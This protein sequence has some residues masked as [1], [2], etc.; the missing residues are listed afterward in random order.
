MSVVSRRIAALMLLSAPVVAQQGV[1]QNLRFEEDWTFLAEPDAQTK[2]Q[3]PDIKLIELGDGWTLT[4]GGQ[5]RIRWQKE[6][7]KSLKGTHPRNNDF[8][9]NRAR[10]SADFRH[11]S[12]FRA[13]VE[14]LDARIWGEELRPTPID[15]NVADVHNGFL[16][17]GKGDTTVR[18]G[19]ME[20]QYGAQRLVSP[21]DWGNT[22]RRF[23]GGLVRQ[24]FDG[25]SVDVFLTKPVVV[26]PDQLDHDDRSQ[27]F[28]GVYSNFSGE[29]KGIDA[30][31]LAYNETT[32]KV[33]GETRTGGFDIYTLGVRPYGKVGA[34]D[35]DVE[36]AHQ[37]GGFGGDTVDAWAYAGRATWSDPQAALKP[38]VG[39]EVDYASGD[40]NPTDGDHES[41]N[42][43]FPLGH[44]YF[45]YLDLVGRS[46]IIDVQPNAVL[47][48]AD[49]TA[50]R[51]A[52]HDYTL[53]D[54]H[55]ALYNAGG[56]KTLVD[57]TG[58][59]GTDVGREVD[60]T[61]MHDVPGLGPH[62]KLLVGYSRFWPGA[63]VEKLGSGSAVN[64]AYV[65]LM[66]TF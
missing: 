59:S 16:E 43:L 21:L 62:G 47:T 33:K 63:F 8:V 41:F 30:Y 22:R 44:A 51:I 49:G 29:S 18:G 13:Y 36:V 53:A 38:K 5:E 7:G 15:R 48:V 12:G 40:G 35:L 45:G 9:L 60:L 34:F 3:Y 20:L 2:H 4:L 58:G 56:A 27:F 39:L 42:Q 28:S 31:V 32:S 64:L 17:Y 23:E 14:I 10:V 52:A 1:F 65:Q 66:F 55:D 25:G 24:G 57:T 11:E 61:L 26:D 50:V 19:R 46:N 37:M 6:T 54:R